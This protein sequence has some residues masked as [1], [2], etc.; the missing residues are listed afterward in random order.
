MENPWLDL[1]LTG[2]FVLECDRAAVENF[3]QTARPEHRLRLDA[4][5]GP[6]LGNHEAPVVLLTLN[7]GFSEQ[8]IVTEAH[9][10][11]WNHACLKHEYL[12]YPFFL[13]DPL[14]A[15]LDGP[16]WWYQRLRTIIERYG[17]E[18]RR[19]VA[20]NILNVEYFPYPSYRA[21]GFHREAAL[22]SQQYG[23]HLVEK[24]MQ[25]QAVIIA[26]RSVQPWLQS[27]KDLSE[28]P[29]LYKLNSTQS[30]YI[31]ERN[32]PAGYPEIIKRL[33]ERFKGWLI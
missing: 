31:T 32:C 28:Y 25:R 5:P 30:V 7:P 11:G 26:M 27:V 3:N 1:P 9:N 8:D 2:E 13:L 22:P 12:D 23:F 21:A 18:G 6:F 24:A 16:K 4:F 33:D 15:E 17:P 14:I 19:F 29:Y 10:M 20:N